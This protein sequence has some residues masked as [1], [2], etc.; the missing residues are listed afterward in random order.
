MV[1]G[2]TFL[3][4]TGGIAGCSRGSGP[5]TASAVSS[6]TAGDTFANPEELQS[7][8]GHL[9]VTLV[10]AATGVPWGSGT[11]YALTYN[12]SAP[13]PTL[14]VRPGDVLTVTLRNLLD[15]P[16]NLHTHGLHVSPSG[17]SDNIFTMVEPGG[18]L[19]YEYL[20]PA[21]HPSGT[22]WYHPHHHGEVASQLMGG[23]AG[24]IVVEDDI[25]TALATTVERIVVLADPRIGNTASVLSASSADK[26]TGRE[27]DA[28]LVNGSLRPRMAA[29]AGTIERWRLVNASPSRYYRLVLT[30][31]SMELIGTDHGR[32]DTPHPVSD[33]LLTPGQRAE[34]I[35][36]LTNP[37]TLSL[38]TVAVDRGS[39]GMGMGRSGSSASRTGAELL[40]V[41]VAAATGPSTTTLPTTL[42]TLG[43]PNALRVDARRTVTLGAMG[44][45]SGAFVIDGRGFDPAVVNTTARLGTTEEWTI[46]NNSMMD[47]PFHLHVWPFRVMARSDG[48]PVDPGWRDTVNV[49]AGHTVTVRV[50][51]LDYAG[52]AV[53]HCHILDHEDLGMMGIIEVK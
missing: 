1:G 38:A 52:K 44:M 37:G 40:T 53:Y 43:D 25:D 42:R 4:A 35:I 51:L 19:T 48:N 26:M 8:D 14:R 47:H 6:G 33:L 10:A 46:R 39:M 27:G 24:V 50:P 49:P 9:A 3:L 34:V 23:M 36:R 5:S 28:V 7:T 12:G 32:L 45:G 18:E 41:D 13:G 21:N 15:R 20:L 16:T 29:T 30:G 22:F 11:R 17:T 2:G 31:A